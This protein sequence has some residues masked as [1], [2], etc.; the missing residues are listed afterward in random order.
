MSPSK[1]VLKR[2][3]C[4][5]ANVR[6]IVKNACYVDLV[7]SSNFNI[8]IFTET[9]LKPHHVLSSLLCNI[10]REYLVIR[11][12]RTNRAGGGVAILLRKGVGAVEVFSQSVDDAYEILSADVILEWCKVRFIV[13]YRAPSCNAVHNRQLIDVVSDLM[14][15]GHSA[16]LLMLRF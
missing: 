11:C 3:S 15:C 12:D 13:V 6:S 4:F 2:L 10:S 1:N 14:G 8:Y 9:W 5:Y 7:L 16:V